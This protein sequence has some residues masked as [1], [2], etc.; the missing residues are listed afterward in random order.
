MSVDI[1]KNSIRHNIG[2]KYSISIWI[3]CIDYR[4][5]SLYIKTVL[6]YF[7]ALKIRLEKTFAWL[8]GRMKEAY[9]SNHD[10]CCGPGFETG[11]GHVGFVVGQNG[12][13]ADFLRVLRSPLQSSFFPP[14][15]PQ[16]PSCIIRGMYNRPMWPQCWDL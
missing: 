11:P 2:K 5:I 15:T 10:S 16:S 9:M 8:T 7:K 1:E 3:Q 4:A 12:A 13:G 6:I 14:M